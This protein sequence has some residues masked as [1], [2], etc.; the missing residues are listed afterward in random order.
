MDGDFSMNKEKSIITKIE[1]Q[2]R[3]KDR[4]NVYINEEFSFACSAE[5]IYTYNLSKDKE[6]D[7]DFLKEIIDKD[8]CIKCKSYALRIIERTHKTE[9][10]IFD[11]LVQKEYDEKAINKTIDFLKEY[12]FID[13]EKYA[14]TYIKDKLKSQGKN[15][16]KYAL[17]NK[18][19]SETLIKKNLSCLDKD[20]EESTALK[21]AEKKYKLLIKNESDVRKIYKKLGDYLVRNGYNL[22]IVQSTLNNIVKEELNHPNTTE[23]QNESKD[24]DISKLYELAEKRYSIIIKSEND[25]RKIYKKLSDY[26]MRRGYSWNNIKSVLNS[27]IK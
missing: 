14:E 25:S 5:L 2:K 11:K 10:Q 16:I 13:D 27:I 6:I 7:M 8:N 21:L 15:K 18:G 1:L 26:L 22:D 19:I 9:K 3:N 24:E 20:I 12:K 4:V 17:I 23:T